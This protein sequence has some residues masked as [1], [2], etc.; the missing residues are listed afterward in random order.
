MAIA[1]RKVE[2]LAL[3]RRL[4]ADAGDLELLLEALGHTDDQV[5]DARTAGAPERAGALGLGP[6]INDD[7]VA[8]EFHGHIVRNHEAELALGTLDR[9]LLAFDLRGCTGRDIDRFLADLRH[10]NLLS[11]LD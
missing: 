6:R 8:L 5:V 1:E 7:G 4:V 11:R 10:E 2:V 3:D 9:N